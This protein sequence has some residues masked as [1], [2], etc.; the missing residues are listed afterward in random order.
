MKI[1]DVTDRRFTQY[2][3]IL[4]NYDYSELVKEL[5]SSE[6]PKT[7]IV[8]VA[9]SRNLEKC[10]IVSLFKECGFGGMDIQVGYVNG[11]NR[12]MNCLEYHKS[13]EFNIPMNDIVLV[14]GNRT[15]INDG[16]FDSSDCEAFFVPAG[17][18]VE[19]YETTLHYA[20][21]NVEED[22]YRMICVLPLGTNGEK[23]YVEEKSY[24]DQM[25]FGV[26][27]WLMA[28]KDAPEVSNG[29]YI[30][31]DGKNINYTDLER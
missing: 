4:S 30:G 20:P 11:V 22:G 16:K 8:Y 29:A 13:A 7:G 10:D 6:I 27:K 31:I 28:H 18:G 26:N 19:L 3:K 12:A 1:Y 2:G 21:F 5:T 24:E 14:L 23:H 25:L 9:S 17:V 15:K